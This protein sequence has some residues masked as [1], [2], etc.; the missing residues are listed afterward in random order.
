MVAQRQHE[1]LGP[2]QRLA[3]EA[4]EGPEHLRFEDLESLGEL[5]FELSPRICRH[6]TSWRSQLPVCLLTGGWPV[7]LVDTAC[8]LILLLLSLQFE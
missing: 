7:Q 5:E 3:R 6:Q 8:V 4:L 2:R 1:Q